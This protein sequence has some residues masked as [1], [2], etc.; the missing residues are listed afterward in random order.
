MSRNLDD[1]LWE[2]THARLELATKLY[3][4]HN[5]TGKDWVPSVEMTDVL[6]AMLGASIEEAQGHFMERFPK[7]D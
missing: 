4:E 2:A 3:R 6:L 7:S 5:R 1:E